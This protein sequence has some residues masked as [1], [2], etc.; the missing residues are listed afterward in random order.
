M[1]LEDRVAQTTVRAAQTVS[2]RRL[3]QWRVLPETE[4]ANQTYLTRSRDTDVGPTS[5]S[6]DPRT[7]GV[8]PYGHWSTNY[9]VIDMTLPCGAALWVTPWVGKGYGS[10]PRQTI[11]QPHTADMALPRSTTSGFGHM[12]RLAIHCPV[13]CV[14]YENSCPTS[15]CPGLV[16]A[17]RESF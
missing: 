2:Q 7:S 12:L 4:I 6:T 10:K 9:K 5:L 3:R 15:V 17:G 8:R 16:D 14:F 1:S 11:L 13:V